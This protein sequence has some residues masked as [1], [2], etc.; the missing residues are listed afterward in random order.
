M[1]GWHEWIDEY[2]DVDGNGQTVIDIDDDEYDEN[3]YRYDEYDD[4]GT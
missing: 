1:F 4:D 2:H 3:V